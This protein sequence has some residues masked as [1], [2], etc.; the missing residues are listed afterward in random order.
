MPIKT[1]INTGKVPVKIYTEDIEPEAR[2]QLLNISQ[3]PFVHSHVAAMPDVHLGKG[4]TVG[5]VI[6]TKGAIIPAAVGVDIGC[7]MN[8]VRLSLKA[9]QLPDNLRGI[10]SAIEAAVPVGFNIHQTEVAKRATIQP[11]HERLE[12]ILDKH[13]KIVRKKPLQTWARQLGT[14]GGGNHFIELC[15]DE[16]DDVWIMLHSGSRGIGNRIGTYFIELAKQDMRRLQINLPDRDLAYLSE[17]TRY[18]DDYVEAVH[19]AQDYAMIN[20]R[21]MM[22]LV[23]DALKEHLP[24]FR[25]EREAINCHHNYVAIE[26]H[27]DQQVYVTRKGAIRAGADE[28]GIIPGSMGTRSYIVRGKGNAEAFHS[29]AHGAGRRM[30]R[31]RAKKQFNLRDLEAQTAGVE[32]R[33]DNSVVD[34]IPGAYKDIDSVME[35][36]TDLVDIVHTLKQVVCVKG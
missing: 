6:P 22:R 28:L 33:K 15:L 7:G 34:E 20:R 4:A 36:Q 16:N 12:R 21:E 1:T 5:A 10:R 25:A 11:L 8:A 19:W 31:A 23:M 27:Y 26:R 2:Q 17:G 9:G 32:C 29:C 30:S 3:L 35:N 24:D 14:L 13:G 18:F